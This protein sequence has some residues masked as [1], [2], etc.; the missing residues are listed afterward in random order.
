MNKPLENTVCPVG[1]PASEKL[2]LFTHFSSHGQRSDS[3]HQIFVNKVLTGM[4]QGDGVE[5]QEYET[6]WDILAVYW[7]SRTKHMKSKLSQT[8][9]DKWWSAHGDLKSKAENRSTGR[10]GWSSVMIF[11]PLCVGRFQKSLPTGDIAH[12]RGQDG[13]RAVTPIYM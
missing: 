10:K 8:I 13:K 1:S 3:P 6:S 7:A 2:K 9:H 4:S 11:N 5:K 12:T